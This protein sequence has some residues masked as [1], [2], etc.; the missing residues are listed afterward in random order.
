MKT[1]E[2]DNIERDLKYSVKEWTGPVM[3]FMNLVMKFWVSLQQGNT[4]TA[5]GRYW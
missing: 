3:G 2:D 1:Q 4:V 5:Q